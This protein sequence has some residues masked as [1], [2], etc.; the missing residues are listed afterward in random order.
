MKT[1]VEYVGLGFA[2]LLFYEFRESE[3]RAKLRGRIN[4]QFYIA[5]SEDHGGN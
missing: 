2:R 4:P 1:E 5:C 3:V